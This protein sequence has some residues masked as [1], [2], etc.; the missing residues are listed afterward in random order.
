MKMWKRILGIAGAA[1][2]AI[3]S[4][5]PVLAEEY[6]LF[7]PPVVDTAQGQLMGFMNEGTY[8]FLGIPYAQAGR[9]EVPQKVEPWEGVRRAQSYGTICPIQ[10]QTEVGADEFAWP[11]RYWPQ[12][13]NCMNLN[14]WTQSLDAAAKRPVIVFFHGGGYRNGSSIESAAYDGKNLSAYGDVVVVTVNHRLNIL[15]F[16][17]LSDYGE[18]YAGTANLGM[19]DLVCSLEWIQENIENFGGDPANVTIFGQSG[20]GGKVNALLRMPS[21]EGL[22][23][24][25]AVM[26]SSYGTIDKAT[27]NAIVDATLVNLGLDSVDALKD[28]DYY[29]LI[30]AAQAACTEVGTNWTPEADGT[31]LQA[32]LCDWANDIPYM[33]STVFA[34]FNYNWNFDGPWKNTW[35]DEEALGYLTEKYGEAAEGIAEAFKAVYPEK[36][37]ADAYFYYAAGR[38]ISRQGVET[39]LADKLAN[40]TAPCY[41]YLFYFEAPVNGGILPFHCSDLIYL[42]HNVDIP[43]ISIAT[44]GG[45]DAHKMQDTMADAFLAFAATGDPSTESLAWAPYTAEEKNIMVFDKES[46]C[47]VLGDE[48]LYTLCADA[49]AAM[50]G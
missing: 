34:E 3:S 44:G 29:N 39:V 32:D 8:A 7:N 4:F 5:A 13:E 12:N 18:A 31:I 28:Y 22:F 43:V 27:N 49:L 37:L 50:A 38:I 33:A 6:D 41:E 40:A 26:S 35:T 47:R 9:F 2:L 46:E 25:A 48:E 1:V 21:A 14:V 19:Q 15:G 16:M 20:G 42:F 17:D 11:H 30:N 45:E 10:N 24:R 36:P 23:H